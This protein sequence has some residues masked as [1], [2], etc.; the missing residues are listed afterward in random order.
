M[1]SR[2][3]LLLDVSLWSA[4]LANLAPSI[5]AVEPYADSFHIDVADGHFVPTLL[6]FPDLVAAIRALTSK[7]LHV[8]LMVDD[9]ARL[10]PPF[11]DA[12]ADIVSVH[13]ETPAAADALALIAR[14][15][16][17]PGLALLLETPVDVL[18]PLLPY[19]RAIIA[20]GTPTGI[21]G[22][23]LAPDAC[24][25]LGEIRA[26]I[27]DRSDVTIYADGGIREHT[28]AQLRAAGADAIVPGSL[29]FGARDRATIHAWL[30]KE[31]L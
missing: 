22:V 21:K 20:M 29:L 30:K 24:A 7:P 14:S 6:F 12:G 1:A 19:A 2:Q 28:V 16:R 9:P 10:A 17:T 18:R 3:P 31:E 5:A 25:R 26:L 11:L 27:G 15:G 23:D 4:D 13:V 8:H